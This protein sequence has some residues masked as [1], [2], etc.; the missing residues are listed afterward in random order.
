METPLVTPL[1]Q[2]EAKAEN[3]PTDKL[4]DFKL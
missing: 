3:K 2:G 4:E 1:Y